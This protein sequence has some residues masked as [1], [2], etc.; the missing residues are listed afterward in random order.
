MQLSRFFR[1]TCLF[2]LAFIS[3]FSIQVVTAQSRFTDIQTHWAR[4]CIEA[5]A[6]R[7]VIGGFPDGRFRPDDAVTRAQ[8]A[9]IAVKAFPTIVGSPSRPAISFQ[10]V[11]A[12][13]WAAD[14]IEK[15]YRANFF[16]GFPNQTFQPNLTIIR[17]QALTALA[18]GLKIEPTQAVDMLKTYGDA[19]A[20]PPYAVS[21]IASATQKGLVVN[22]PTTQRLEPMKPASRGEVAAFVCRALPETAGLVSSQYIPSAVAKREIRGVWLTNIDSDVLFNASK[23][24]NAVSELSRLNFNTLYPVVWNWGYTLYPS[25]VMKQDLGVEVDPRAIAAGLRERDMLNQIV[26]EGHDKGM[27]VIPWF[28]FGF[29]A[30]KESELAQK[31]KDWWTTK[32]DGSADGDPRSLDGRQVP[33]WFNPFKPEVQTFMVDLVTEVVTNYD[34]DGV[35]FDDHFGLPIEFGYDDF[36]VKLYQQEHNGKSPPRYDLARCEKAG[37]KDACPEFLAKDPQWAEWLRW[38][39]NKIEEV[40]K[41]V[42]QSVKSQKPKVIIGLSPLDLPYAYERALV[43]WHKWEQDGLIEELIPQIYFQ[44]QKFVDRIEPATHP[45]LKQARDRIP[46]AIGI[47][48]GLSST[49]RPMDELRRQVQA[50]RD[51]GYAGMSFFFYETLW[52]NS[53]EP[54]ETRKAGWQT[55]FLSKLERAKL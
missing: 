24:S 25:Q 40:L 53:P 43:D 42:F 34:V 8:F 39:S 7:N 55:L 52:N 17:A 3:V 29:F 2:L 20:I 5:L 27:A 4:P 28:E 30:P 14:A 49:P 46:T 9:A 12:T 15:A 13:Y 44:G 37:M 21:A 35:Q 19:G 23:L 47:L 45:E 18:N 33:I 31:H 11:P 22:Y 26:T 50:V 48:S 16:S 32:Q 6:Q 51:R 41:Q 36:T 10:D 1:I 54:V 38:R